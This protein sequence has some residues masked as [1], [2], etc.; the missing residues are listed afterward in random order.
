[1]L[2]IGRLIGE[3]LAGP[4][5]VVR[6]DPDGED[7]TGVRDCDLGLIQACWVPCKDPRRA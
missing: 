5:L 4:V 1:M 2:N 3:P 6:A 7:F